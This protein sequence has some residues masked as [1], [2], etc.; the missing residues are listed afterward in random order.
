MGCLDNKFA[1][2]TGATRGLG[3]EIASRFA[4]EG[5]SVALVGRDPVAL[6]EAQHRI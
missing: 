5:A 2:I 1:L 4:W 3:L 6:E